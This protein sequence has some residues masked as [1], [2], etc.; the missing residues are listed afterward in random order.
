[1]NPIRSLVEKGPRELGR[2]FKKGMSE[3]LLQWPVK[4]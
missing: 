2:C 3:A 1:M 4:L